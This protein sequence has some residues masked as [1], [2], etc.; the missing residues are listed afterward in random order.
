MRPRDFY[1]RD[2][3]DV[4]VERV[5]CSA[6]SSPCSFCHFNRKGGCDIGSSGIP[7]L[8]DCGKTFHFVKVDT[9]SDPYFCK[10]FEYNGHKIKPISAPGCSSGPYAAC[11]FSG[12]TDCFSEYA[13]YGIDT[14]SFR[15]FI[16]VSGEPSW[17]KEEKEGEEE[18]EEEE[19]ANLP[20]LEDLKNFVETKADKLI[21]DS[22]G[23]SY[24]LIEGYGC[25]GCVFYVEGCCKKPRE[26]P[27]CK[28][29]HV[30][31]RTSTEPLKVVSG[32]QSYLL[33]N[34]G[35]CHECC[36][37]NTRELCSRPADMTSCRTMNP[38]HYE[39]MNKSELDIDQAI[40]VLAELERF[41]YRHISGTQ[42]ITISS[43]TVMPVKEPPPSKSNIVFLEES[44]FEL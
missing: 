11:V 15:R 7:K 12:C 10:K 40:L 33:V 29:L 41:S 30:Y 21:T 16:T 8:P 22:V 35:G 4:V 20:S 1:Y 6:L 32:D 28:R 38:S 36:F 34:S 5:N 31:V 3:D 19:S 23:N 24:K 14:C 27:E 37:Y 44:K 17:K 39:K 42:S 18:E 25:S 9:D 13:K 26:I 43:S 2:S